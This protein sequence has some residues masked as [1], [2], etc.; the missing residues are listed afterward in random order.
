MSQLALYSIS[1]GLISATLILVLRKYNFLD[2]YELNKKKWM[3]NRCEF[4]LSFWICVGVGVVI[5]LFRWELLPLIAPL[6]AVAIVF[7]VVK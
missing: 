6:L 1:E 5:A 2:F 4:C 3:P 7:N